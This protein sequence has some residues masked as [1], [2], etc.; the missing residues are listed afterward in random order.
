MRGVKICL[1]ILDPIRGR[2]KSLTGWSGG[3]KSPSGWLEGVK[4]LLSFSSF[5]KHKKKSFTFK[6]TIKINFKQIF[7]SFCKKFGFQ[8]KIKEGRL[9]GF[10]TSVHKLLTEHKQRWRHKQEFLQLVFCTESQFVLG[11]TSNG[12]AA[13]SMFIVICYL[14]AV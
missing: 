10:H 2:E 6:S 8:E 1:Y 14:N 12:V 13:S 4:Y 11:F 7:S 9:R 5:Q 3:V